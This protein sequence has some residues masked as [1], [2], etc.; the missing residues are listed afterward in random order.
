M[1]S[2]P[3]CPPSHVDE[4]VADRSLA[5]HENCAVVLAFTVCCVAGI[6][7]NA[8]FEVTLSGPMQGIWFWSLFGLDIGL[9]IIYRA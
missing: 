1:G 4:V 9:A 8:A 5:G 7:I 6:F 3:S 2:P